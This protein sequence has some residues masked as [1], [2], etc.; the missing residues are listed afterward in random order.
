MDEC[1]T[2]NVDNTQTSSTEASTSG[3]GS[4]SG[5]S[6]SIGSLAGFSSEVEGAGSVMKR[7]SDIT[8]WCNFAQQ[9]S[10]PTIHEKLHNSQKSHNFNKINR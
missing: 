10:N 3:S 9:M 6:V 8:R 1:K 4:G 7:P 5:I 2:H